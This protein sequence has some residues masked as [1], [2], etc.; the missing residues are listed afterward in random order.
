MKILLYEPYLKMLGEELERQNMVGEILLAENTH[1][2]L[3]ICQQDMSTD[4]ATYFGP[5]KTLQEAAQ[6]VAQR[7]GLSGN[8]LTQAG[9]DYFQRYAPLPGFT[10]RGLH[11]YFAPLGYLLTMFLLFGEQQASETMRE[12]VEKEG[13]AT[14][15]DVFQCVKAYLPKQSVPLQI[16]EKIEQMFVR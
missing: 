9:E 6:K 3:D 16:Q 11:M 10:Y 7:E 12:L 2:L 13:L 5:G 4:I 15:E 1:L 8:W 14:R